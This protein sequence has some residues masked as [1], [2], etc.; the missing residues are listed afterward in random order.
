M[1]VIAEGMPGTAMPAWR[2]KLSEQER[3]DV[4]AYIKRFSSAFASGGAK[5]VQLSKDPGTSDQAIADG[6]AVFT[7]LQCAKCHGL[8]GR[9]NGTSAPTL[10]DDWGHPIRAADLTERWKFRGGSDV[11]SIY[12]RL[13]TGLDG[14]PMPSFTDAIDQKLITDEQLWH[15]AAYVHS[16]SPEPPRVR[17]VIRAALVVA[18]PA[19]PDD[20]VWE[21]AERYWIPVVGQVIAKPRWFAPTVDG[22]W[23]QAMHDG[24]RLA[25]R[26]TWDDPS[27]SPAPAWNEWLSRLDTTLT[28]VDGPLPAQQGPDRLSVQWPMRAGDDME[29]PYFL[30]GDARRPVRLWR[31]TSAPD[32]VEVGTA[33][34]IGTFAATGGEDSVS[35]VARYDAGQWR[36]QLVRALRPRDTTTGPVF[37][38]GRAVPVAVFV[39]DGSNG[40]DDVRN[41]V[42]TWYAIHLDVPTPARVYAAPAVTVLLTAGLG[43]LLVTRAQRRETESGYFTRED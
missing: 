42:S 2:E 7:K 35:H 21:Q 26:L 43:L 6:R 31:W 34:G 12:A 13:R 38:P 4:V 9:G 25:L 11:P 14:T 5:P 23:I 3:R 8:G 29:R 15:V 36:L 39:A 28:T 10:K 1:H 20:R 33:R 17:E 19:T 16:L 27:S 24:R 22:V 37:A 41:A 32:R 18:L 30:G 40:E